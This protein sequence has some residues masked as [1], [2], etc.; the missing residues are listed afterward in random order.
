MNCTPN[1]SPTSVPC[2]LM[3]GW[4]NPGNSVRDGVGK[5]SFKRERGRSISNIWKGLEASSKSMAGRCSSGR[6]CCLKNRKTPGSSLPPL[7]RSS[8]VTKPITPLTS[9][10][11]SSHPVACP[12]VWLREPQLGEAFPV[13]GRYPKP[14]SGPPFE[15]PWITRPKGSFSR[16]GATVETINL[17][18]L[19]IRRFFS[20]LTMPGQ[21]LPQMSRP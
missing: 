18:Q 5:K 12:F 19:S 15:T 11:K 14:T 9:R 3:W 1:T 2:N 13:V 4:T 21:A 7:H 17:G 16:V 8:G 20:E 10:P 6:T